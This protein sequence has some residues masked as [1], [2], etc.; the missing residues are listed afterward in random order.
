MF[1]EFG[2]LAAVRNLN[3]STLAVISLALATV[4]LVSALILGQGSREG[5]MPQNAGFWAGTLR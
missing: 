5:R 3:R 4:I 1:F 2:W